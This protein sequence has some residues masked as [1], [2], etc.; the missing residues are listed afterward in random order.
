MDLLVT[1][2]RNSSNWWCCFSRTKTIHK[3]NKIMDSLL[4][5]RRVPIRRLT[6]IWVRDWCRPRKCLPSP[7]SKCSPR[8][9]P[10]KITMTTVEWLI[11]VWAT[12]LDTCHK[13]LVKAI[14]AV[15]TPTSISPMILK[16]SPRCLLQ[17]RL[18]CTVDIL[19]R[20][21][22]RP[23]LVSSFRSRWISS[24]MWAPC[25]DLINLKPCKVILNLAVVRK[26]HISHL[27]IAT[28]ITRTSTTCR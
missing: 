12:L 15:T 17:Q 10:C 13:L 6:R 1:Q 27:R 5:I 18:R 28:E 19:C 23:H 21:N 9:Q 25:R 16:V 4:G 20:I 2:C 3:C 7:S 22:I 8:R 14:W 24:G 26:L 11:R